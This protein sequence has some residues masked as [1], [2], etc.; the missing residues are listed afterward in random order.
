MS[1]TT[2]DLLRH[3]ETEGEGVYRGQQD[4]L[5]TEIGRE[6][7]QSVLT[8]ELPWQQIIHTAHRIDLLHLELFSP[9]SVC[10]GPML[11]TDLRDA[12]LKTDLPT[13]IRR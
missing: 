10:D 8:D 11:A 7:M 13:I 3:G 2:I 12:D 5:L 1:V 9:T 4:Y 6:Q